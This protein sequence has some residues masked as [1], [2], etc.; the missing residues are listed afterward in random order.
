MIQDPTLV[1]DEDGPIEM[2]REG[3]MLDQGDS[4]HCYIHGVSR[5]VVFIDLLL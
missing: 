4:D 1:E 5:R 2:N 3:G